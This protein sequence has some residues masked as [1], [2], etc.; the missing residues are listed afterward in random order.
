MKQILLSHGGGGEETQKLIK[1]LFFKYFS[2]PILEKMEDAAVLETGSKLAFTTDSFTVSPIFFKG[3]DIGKLAVAGTVND[4]SMMGA[5]PLYMSCSFIIE[6]GLPFEDLEKIVSSM[7]EETKKS[8]VQIVTGDTKVVPK[9]SADKIFINTTGI[10]EIVY[11]G[12]SA[13]NV[14]ERDV[15]LVSG[16]IGDHGACIMAQREGIE[17]EGNIASDC[18][19]LWSLVKDLINAEILIKAM[20]DPTRGGLS[21]VLN[22]W[23]EQS[24]IGIEIEE[25]KIPLKDEVQGMCELLGLDPFSLANEGKLILAVPEEDAEKALEIMKSNELGKDAQIIGKAISDYRGK[26]ILKSPYGS[27]RILE[28]PAGELLPRIC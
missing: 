3:G 22:E 6:E 25:E 28:P 13:H 14:R 1:E 17:L 24:N 5:K 26:V 27:K 15:I 23:A 11:E 18:A 9:G 7:A 12:I 4:L 16:T 21:A 8:G 2:N 19:S 20:R 10:G